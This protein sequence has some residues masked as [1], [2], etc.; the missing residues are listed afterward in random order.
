MFLAEELDHPSWVDKIVVTLLL[1]LRDWLMAVP[2]AD[3]EKQFSHT[4]HDTI[5]TVFE[6][7]TSWW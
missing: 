7:S 3:I 5:R 4:L 1:L 6:V 2:L